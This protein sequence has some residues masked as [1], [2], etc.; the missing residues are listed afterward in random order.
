VDINIENILKTWLPEDICQEYID[1][2]HRPIV[3]KTEKHHI[4][5]RSLFPEHIKNPNN[6]IELSIYDHLE[7][8]ECLAKTNEHKMILAFNFMFTANYRRYSTLTEDQ[9]LKVKVKRTKARLAMSDVK[10]EQ[11]KLYIGEK[12]PFYGKTH[13]D[14][15]KAIISS[16]HKGKKLS[17]DHIAILVACHKG[18]PKRKVKC[19]H[20]GQL[21]AI[22]AKNRRHFDNC[23]YKEN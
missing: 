12:N 3:G 19:P 9:K 15:T 1:I 11:G 4:L 21:I 5:P 22:H 6:L 20:C 8:H 13:S 23:A 10:S 18:K 2:L 14:E 16:H 17:A 7:A